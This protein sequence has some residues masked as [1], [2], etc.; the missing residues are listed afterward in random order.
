MVEEVIT[1]LGLAPQENRVQTESGS[2]AWGLMKGSAQVFVFINDNTADEEYNTIQVV[3][4]VVTLPE[5]PSMQTALF[6]HLLD[7]NA[8]E[9]NGA[10]FGLKGETVVITVDRSTQDL[11]R[12]EVKDMILR[13]GFYADYYDDTLVSQFGGQ[14]HAD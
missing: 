5:A 14:R 2:P 11:N 12:S 13:V 1:E 9:I 10:A 6:R 3:S 8:R 4:P 7:L